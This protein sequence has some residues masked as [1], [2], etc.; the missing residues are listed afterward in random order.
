MYSTVQDLSRYRE[1]IIEDAVNTFKDTKLFSGQET[2]S[3]DVARVVIEGLLDLLM[4]PEESQDLPTLRLYMEWLFKLIRKDSVKTDMTVNFLDT[5]A[6]IIKK[7]L[8]NKEDADI[9]SF[10]ARCKDIVENKRNHLAK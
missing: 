3:G 7:P 6:Q 1:R 8:N 2:P 9:D 4:E 10:F 5:F